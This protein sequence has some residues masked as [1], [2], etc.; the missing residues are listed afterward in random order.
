M[1][2]ELVLQTLLL[3]NNAFLLQAPSPARE[4][5]LASNF[6]EAD[7]W[8]A[9]KLKAAPATCVLVEDKERGKCLKVT[10][11]RGQSTGA[12]F[13]Y[14][15]QQQLGQEPEEIF[16]RYDLKLDPSWKNA[17]DGGKLP[18]ISG[19]YG[20]AGWGGRKVNGSDGWS[21]RGHFRRPGPNTTDIG[22]YCYHADMKTKYGDIF[23]FIPPLEYDRWYRV[24]MLCKL[25]TPGKDGEPG[26][27]DGM[28]RAWIDGKPAFERTDLR[29]RDV[30]KLK[31]ETI[32]IN[33]YHGG[34]RPA[35]QDLHLYLD[36]IVIA[37]ARIGL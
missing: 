31:I 28:L 27:K 25:N 18:G 5:I 6:E 33:V 35:P 19:T 24:E 23:K 15:F 8:R 4:F 36:N 29:F 22:Y 7:W 30:A 21:A 9:W 10:I 16:F 12:N 20:K 26:M 13:H 11:P 34:T 1:P 3:V 37:R 17:S 32:W 2:G 14:R